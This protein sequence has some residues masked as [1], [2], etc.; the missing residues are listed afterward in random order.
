MD[1]VP[2]FARRL[3]HS[4]HLFLEP[5]MGRSA[6]RLGGVLCARLDLAPLAIASA[7]RIRRLRRIVCRRGCVVD[8]NPAVAS[9]TV[10]AGDLYVSLAFRSMSAGGSLIVMTFGSVS[11]SR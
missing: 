9:S 5:A 11:I 2:G 10:A 1:F 3:G 8:I 4:G 7:A 6:A